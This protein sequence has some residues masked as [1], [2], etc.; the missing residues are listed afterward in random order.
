MKRLK[1]LKG[2]YMVL[3]TMQDEQK[4]SLIELARKIKPLISKMDS[5]PIGYRTSTEDP[6]NFYSQTL[7]SC[8][9]GLLSCGM[10]KYSDK[11][12]ITDFGV[13]AINNDSTFFADVPE[14]FKKEIIKCS[15]DKGN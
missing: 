3:Y 12:E 5:P 7:F 8:L 2:E 11:I 1:R 4:R 6:I 14:K 9:D 13:R 10:L 15:Q